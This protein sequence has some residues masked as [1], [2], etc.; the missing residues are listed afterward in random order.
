MKNFID[1]VSTGHKKSFFDLAEEANNI[2]IRLVLESVGCI[3]KGTE[4]NLKCLSPFRSNPSMGSFNINTV[5]NIFHD[6]SID[7]AG[8]PIKFYMEYYNLNF[9]DATKK[10]AEEYQLGSFYGRISEKAKMRILKPKYEVKKLNLELIDKVYRLFLSMI[11]LSDEDKKFLIGRGLSDEEIEKQMFRSYPRR[12][13]SFREKFEEA[14]IEKFGTTDVLFEVPGFFKRKNE[15]FS[16]AYAKGILFPSINWK[17]QVCGLQV[18]NVRYFWISSANCLAKDEKET[19]E[20]DGL[21]PGSPVSFI[22]SKWTKKMCLTEGL[23]KSLAIVKKWKMS[24][25]S[26]QGINNWR[27]FVKEL[28][29]IKEKYKDLS[30]LVVFYDSDMARNLNVL[31]QALKLGE[32]ISKIDLKVEYSVWKY[33]EKT[34][35][36]DDLIHSVN[37]PKSM[38]KVLKF[39][40]FKKVVDLIN[41]EFKEEIESKNEI[42]KEKLNNFFNLVVFCK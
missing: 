30:G 24:T 19:F 10:L 38:I 9:V 5:K 12:T 17:N 32:E 42:D 33:D 20:R 23:F 35:G 28:P 18:R 7:L 14:V 1:N 6:W 29:Q 37:E 22:E 16:Y 31:N 26:I 8:G 39:E 36:I 34:K 2:P 4:P 21:S 11:T 40:E 15:H 25:F 27:A 3:F 13:I 41:E